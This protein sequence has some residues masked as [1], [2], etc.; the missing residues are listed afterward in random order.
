M[1]NEPSP[2]NELPESVSCTIEEAMAFAVELHRQG[3][4]I[5]AEKIY[6]QI[7]Q[8]QP[9]QVDALHFLGVACC[10]LG[11]RD[12][13]V[14]LIRRALSHAPDYAGAH[15]NLGNVYKEMGQGEEA[16]A[17]YRRALA[18]DP[19]L[20]DAHHNLGVMQ[21]SVGEYE[22]AAASFQRA[23]QLNPALDGAQMDLATTLAALRSEGRLEEAAG[24][25]RR[26]L[27]L[28]PHNEVAR[29]L[30]A[31]FTGETIPERASDGYVQQLFDAY[32]QDFDAKLERLDYAAPQLVA[33]AV[34]EYVMP[35]GGLA[36]LD[37]GCGT[38]LSGVTLKPYARRLVGVDLS[39]AMLAKARER[40]IYDD[41]WEGE[42][43]ACLEQCGE[44]FDLV[45]AVDTLNYFGQLSGVLRA[46]RAVLR[47]N[48]HIVFTL[49]CARDEKQ[50]APYQLEAT[51]RYTHRRSAVEDELQTADLYVDSFQPCVLR[52]DFNQPVQGWLVVASIPS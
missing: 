12:E 46:M 48:G 10:Q 52:R 34:K 21:R 41:L 35:A 2:S 20:A 26:W 51:G 33:Q 4:L 49:E 38:G 32:A 44:Q 3:R 22:A 17:C 18:A 50:D 1:S 16:T 13:A 39:P 23:V 36:V 40:Q 15:N 29:H 27:E 14:T 7:L 42:L 6:R 24:V 5:D 30:L 37:A 28:S 8:V 45:A 47:S 9:T 11:K 25:V 19:N 31:A 43:V